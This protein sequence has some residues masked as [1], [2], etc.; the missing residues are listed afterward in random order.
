MHQREG[1][2]ACLHNGQ[3]GFVPPRF[4][5]RIAYALRYAPVPVLYPLP[6]PAVPVPHRLSAGCSDWKY[7]VPLFFSATKNS[8]ANECPA[9]FRKG[10]KHNERKRLVALSSLLHALTL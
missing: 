8:E 10:E 2:A 6:C 5:N 7:P 3:R 1:G 9:A 4:R